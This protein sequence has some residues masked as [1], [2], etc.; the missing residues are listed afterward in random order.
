MEA[1]TDQLARRPVRPWPALPEQANAVDGLLAHLDV[2]AVDFAA[3]ARGLA[4]ADR[5][6]E[7]WTAPDETPPI[8]RSYGGTIADLLTHSMHHRAHLLAMLDRLGLPDL[9][10]G[11]LPNWERLAREAT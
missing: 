10:E 5:L 6:D 11:D 7:L 2:I 1:W 3:T 4:T 8:Q 9:I